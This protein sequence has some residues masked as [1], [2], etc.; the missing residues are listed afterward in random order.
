VIEKK[1]G[2]PVVLF[3]VSSGI[4]WGIIEHGHRED[5]IYKG[6]ENESD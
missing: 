3:M 2:F 5:N 1:G 4:L 6:N